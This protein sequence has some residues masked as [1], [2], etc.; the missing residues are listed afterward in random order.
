MISTSRSSRC[1]FIFGLGVAFLFA[2]AEPA[3]TAPTLIDRLE[4]SVNSAIILH[5]DVMRFRKTEKLRAQLDPLFSGTSVAAKGSAATDRDIIDFLIDEKIV[6]QLFPVS[7]AEVEQE[8]NSIQ[9]NNRI[10]RASLRS[11]LAQQG[12]A[13]EDY[14]ELIRA[15][16]SKRNLIDR[17]IRTKVSVTDADVK[18]YFYNKYSKESSSR[19]YKLKIIVL[20]ASN[21]KS[22][23]EAKSAAQLARKALEQGEAFED[24][25]K[26]Y[27]DD[28]S[29]ET[30]GELGTLTEEQ[31]S[32][33]IR[34]QVK[35][36][37]IGQVSEIFGTPATGYYLLKL[38]DVESGESAR[39]EKLKDEIRNQLLA[40]EYQHQISLW[41]DRQ[42][43]NAFIH[44][45]GENPL[46]GLPALSSGKDSR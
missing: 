21:Y 40:S 8:I 46:Q 41:L 18:N 39:L 17:D 20:S 4:A 24:V 31:M 7:D 9:A 36:L 37:R 27:S 22:G 30:G 43:Q 45:A 28:S 1:G 26:R 11:A 5:S 10:D 6:S 38:V 35:K 29:A 32:P 19:S 33:A 15:S 2:G 16:A 12:F 34:E 13:F 3:W 42:R 44:R 23:A 14:F 25:A